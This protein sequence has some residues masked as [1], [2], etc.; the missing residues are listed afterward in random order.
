MLL[1]FDMEAGSESQ[2][3][4]YSCV[5]RVCGQVRVPGEGKL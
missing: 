4:K 3:E 1:V 2:S 5:V